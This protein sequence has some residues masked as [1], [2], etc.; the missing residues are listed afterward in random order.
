MTV[1]RPDQYIICRDELNYR[2]TADRLKKELGGE[3]P[4]AVMAF[5]QANAPHGWVQLAD[6]EYTVGGTVKTFEVIPTAPLFDATGSNLEQVMKVRKV[7]VPA[8]SHG[9]TDNGHTHGTIKH[10]HNHSI[11]DPSHNHKSINRSVEST[12]Y[13]ATDT[14]DINLPD[15]STYV[16]TDTDVETNSVNN[17]SLYSTRASTTTNKTG[18]TVNS[19]SNKN[20]ATNGAKTGLTIN[21]SADNSNNFSVKYCNVIL[22]RKS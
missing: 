13:T 1:Q 22:C 6:S 3:Q 8:H 16:E 19:S 11:T 12:D 9:F 17:S 18:I 14:E 5:Y 15:S 20:A 7:P 4:G 10:N 2:I 21:N